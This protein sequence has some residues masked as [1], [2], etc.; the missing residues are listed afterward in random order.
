[1]S[2]TQHII[3]CFRKQYSHTKGTS[4]KV[5]LSNIKRIEDEGSPM[6]MAKE[7]ISLLQISII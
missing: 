2:I 6:C 7:I 4:T 1:M 5:N 3:M